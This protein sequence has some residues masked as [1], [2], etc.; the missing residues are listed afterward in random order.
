MIPTYST[1]FETVFV[2]EGVN[3]SLPELGASRLKWFWGTPPSSLAQNRVCLTFLQFSLP[4]TP[5]FCHL[6]AGKKAFDPPCQ[7]PVAFV[8]SLNVQF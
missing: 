1:C 6:Y 4:T 2:S 5:L 8:T 3:K 7:T